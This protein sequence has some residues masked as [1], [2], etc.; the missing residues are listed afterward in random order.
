M[1][2]ARVILFTYHPIRYGAEDYWHYDE[3]R[4]LRAQQQPEIYVHILNLVTDMF[5]CSWSA[6]AQAK[7]QYNE[8][9]FIDRWGNNV[10]N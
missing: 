3:N 10:C 2:I 5:Q 7:Q 4:H 1:Y 6:G 9:Q 8:K